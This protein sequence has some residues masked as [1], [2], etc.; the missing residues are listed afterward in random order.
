MDPS[1]RY[2]RIIGGPERSV[3]HRGSTA[4]MAEFLDAFPPSKAS[5]ADVA[6]IGV[7]APQDEHLRPAEVDTEAPGTS[8]GD[9]EEQMLWE[10]D[11]TDAVGQEGTR[12]ALVRRSRCLELRGP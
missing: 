6:W 12:I 3:W 9:R 11:K 7:S 5:C 4:T 1:H 10:W 2:E 8:R